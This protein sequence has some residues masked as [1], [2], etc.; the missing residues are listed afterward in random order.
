[1]EVLEKKLKK[2]LTTCTID[3]FL[4]PKEAPYT[5]PQKNYVPFVYVDQKSR[6]VHIVNDY[7]LQGAWGMQNIYSGA[8]FLAERLVKNSENKERVRLHEMEEGHDFFRDE[9]IT[10]IR[11]YTLDT[12]PFTTYDKYGA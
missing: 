11:S 12:S 3:D 4:S 6:R 7:I 1:M 8:V 2:E 5:I 10:R 9:L